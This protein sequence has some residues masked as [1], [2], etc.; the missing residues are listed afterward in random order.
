VSLVIDANLVSAIVLPLPYSEPATQRITGWKQDGVELLAPSLLEYE[1]GAVLRK[2]VVAGLLSTPLA[3]EA[4]R[5]VMALNIRCLPPTLELH[6]SALRWADRL[7]HSKTYHAHYLALAE[8]QG[9][10]LWTADRRLVNGARQAGV[11]WVHWI[12]ESE[13]TN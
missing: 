5:R 10:G 4:I 1:L 6:E 7:G 3:T 13:V 12:G 2:A 9:V 8:Q 11:D